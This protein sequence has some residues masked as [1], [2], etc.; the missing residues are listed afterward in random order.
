MNINNTSNFKEL[1]ESNSY[2]LDKTYMIEELLD[3]KGY[4][5]IF[6]RPSKY[7]KSLF[8]SMLDNFFNI[9]YKDIN[10]NLF[11]DLKISKSKYYQELSSKPVIVLD[12]KTLTQNNYDDMMNEFRNILMRLYDSKKYILGKIGRFADKGFSEYLNG[13]NNNLSD[14]ILYLSKWLYDYYNKQV[15]ILVDGY[16]HALESASKFGFL[17]MLLSFMDHML[18][19]TMK[20]NKYLEFGIV[21]GILRPSEPGICGGFNNYCLYSLYDD[22]FNDFFGF[23]KEEVR[24]VLKDFNLALT[25]EVEDMYDNDNFNPWSIINYC[26]TKELKP[27]ITLSDFIIDNIK[28]CTDYSKECIENLLKDEDVYYRYDLF[29]SYKNIDR[30]ILNILFFN[31]FLKIITKESKYFGKETY[32]KLVNKEAKKYLERIDMNG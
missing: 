8:I 24:K 22:R 23:T 16:D 17:D 26:K 2:Y 3:R 10:K 25:K 20:D 31:G 15:I 30:N 27:Y 12:L 29:T 4:V 28:K 18:D 14:A 9:E 11:K 1:I 5:T 21:T 13:S 19:M 7:G 32:V 6:L